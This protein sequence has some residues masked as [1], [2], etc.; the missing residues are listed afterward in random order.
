MNHVLHFHKCR[1]W[2]NGLAGKRDLTGMAA[3]LLFCLA[4]TAAAANESAEP[5][6]PFRYRSGVR[7]SIGRH[8]LNGKCLSTLAESLREKTGFVELRFDD[9]GFLTLGDRTRIEGGSVVARDLV[10]AAVDGVK[11]LVLEDH[12]YSRQVSFAKLSASIIY[13]NRR[14]GQQ[15]E[16]RTVKIDFADFS[17]LQGE[18]ELLAAFDVGFVVLHELAH[19]ALGLRDA[20]SAEAEPGDC[21]NYINRIRRELDLPERLRY[22]AQRKLAT[23]GP[24]LSDRWAELSFVRVVSKGGK[25]KIERSYLRWNLAVVGDS[26][27]AH[28]IE[29]PASERVKTVAGI[30]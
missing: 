25:H 26:I 5:H 13:Q 11:A 17:N 2:W 9:D 4:T 22:R 28:T 30:Q 14:T 23:V 19:G 3:L 18:R 21:E 20:A 8:Q 1:L 12:S 6:D 16:V 10:A 29:S 24:D 27:G 7:N 15:L